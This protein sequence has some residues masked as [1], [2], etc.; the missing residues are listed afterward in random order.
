MTSL[1]VIYIYVESLVQKSTKSPLFL[2]FAWIL[3]IFQQTV[4]T[5]NELIDIFKVAISEY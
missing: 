5:L 2:D 4:G 1:D 3:D